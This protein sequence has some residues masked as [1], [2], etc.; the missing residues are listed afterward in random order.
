MEWRNTD[1]AP[2]DGSTF[3]AYTADFCGGGPYNERIQEARWSGKT[4][5]DPIGHFRSDNG[6]I[7]MCW[8]PSPRYPNREELRKLVR[9][10]A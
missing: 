3:L 7:V 6:Q 10:I 1:T 5:D 9:V 8:M 4:P 2:R